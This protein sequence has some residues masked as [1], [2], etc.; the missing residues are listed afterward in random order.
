[1][2]TLA[3]YKALNREWQ[4]ARTAWLAVWRIEDQTEEHRALVKTHQTEMENL[5]E[6]MWNARRELV[7]QGI[8][9]P[10]RI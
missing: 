9:E 6:E 10:R 8:V 5:H 2:Q 3:D 1:M 7:A 4:A